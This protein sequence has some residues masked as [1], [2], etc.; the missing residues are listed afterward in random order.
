MAPHVFQRTSHCPR[1]A[2]YTYYIIEVT[3]NHKPNPEKLAQVI[4]ENLDVP[5]LYVSQQASLSLY[6]SGRTTD[7]V[8]NSL[9]SGV[10]DIV[11]IYEG[12]VLKHA[13]M[14]SKLAMKNGNDFIVIVLL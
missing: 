5:A 9:G 12:H 7:V 3:W 14:R 13:I 2:S 4:L 11:P 6:A 1:G 8:L 10:T